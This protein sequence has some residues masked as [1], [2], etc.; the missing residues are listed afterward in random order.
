MTGLC[1][2]ESEPI[3]RCRSYL[4]V[5][6]STYAVICFSSPLRK[7]NKSVIEA[8]KSLNF[9]QVVQSVA[10]IQQIFLWFCFWPL[11]R[12]IS[13]CGTDQEFSVERFWLMKASPW[14][15]Q[16]LQMLRNDVLWPQIDLLSTKWQP[17][18][19]PGPDGS[20]YSI[21]ELSTLKCHTL[22]GALMAWKS[23]V[24]R[25]SWT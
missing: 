23:A 10:N 25:D 20:N 17:T 12:S 15:S 3:R 14:W 22:E 24:P 5:A 21:Y 6:V 19:V 8:K 18:I 11:T 7:P 9:S 13:P 2:V 4:Y 16:S 1:G